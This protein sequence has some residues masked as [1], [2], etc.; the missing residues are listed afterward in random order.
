MLKLILSILLTVNIFCITGV[1][2]APTKASV[3]VTE[4]VNTMT[5]ESL[6]TRIQAMG[7]ECT[8]AKDD[9]GKD[10]TYLIYRAQGYKVAAFVPAPNI[11]ELDNVFTDVHPSLETMNQWNRDNRFTVAYIGEDKSVILQSSLD[12]DGGVTHDGFVAFFNNYRDAVAK[13]A[14][15]VVAHEEKAK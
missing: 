6:Q 8:R 14:L 10:D 1:T 2:Q 7:F 9:S 3:A 11:I 12:L 15:F 13:W 4:V 5:L